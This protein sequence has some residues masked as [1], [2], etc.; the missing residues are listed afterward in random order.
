[1]DNESTEKQMISQMKP[2]ITKYDE[3]IHDRFGSDTYSEQRENA[4][5]PVTVNSGDT[6]SADASKNQQDK[7]PIGFDCIVSIPSINLEKIVYTGAVRDKQ[8][9]QYNLITSAEDMFYKN[10]GNYIICGHNSQLYG[11]SLNRLKELRIG[12]YVYIYSE[13]DIHRYEIYSIEYE[14]MSDTSTFCAQ[15]EHR[16]ITII[17]CARYAGDNQ[18]IVIKCQLK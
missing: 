13:N 15:T 1:M 4:E 7:L 18:Y 8:L 6:T 3:P 16:E 17:S 12:E 5:E 9:Q 10:G 2:D 11:H 14:I